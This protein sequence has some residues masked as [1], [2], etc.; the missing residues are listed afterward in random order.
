MSTDKPIKIGRG[1]NI[2][3]WVDLPDNGTKVINYIL[4]A[5]NFKDARAMIPELRHYL[6]ECYSIKKRDIS[7]EQ[8]ERMNCRNLYFPTSKKLEAIISPNLNSLFPN[9]P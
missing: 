8:L 2:K 9:Y 7:I 5:K 4:V 3:I 6:S 1:Y